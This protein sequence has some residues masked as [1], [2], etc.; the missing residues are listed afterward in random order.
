MTNR[1][2]T[3]SRKMMQDALLNLLKEKPYQKISIT[4][5]NQRADLS[6][7][8]FYEHFESKDDLLISLVD[9]ILEPIFVEMT[10]A[11]AAS[12]HGT[13]SETAF[14]M[15]FEQWQ[16]NEEVLELIR[17]TKSD[18]LILERLHTWFQSA[19]DEALYP[20]IKNYNQLM[21]DYTISLIAGAFYMALIRWA[22][23]GMRHPPELMGRYLFAVLGPPG[24]LETRLE[25]TE[26]F[27]QYSA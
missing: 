15:L 17:Q 13:R 9:D 27:D 11:I 19:R 21:A 3:R 23:E 2:A 7:R 8:T 10:E 24:L 20:Q 14:I 1:Q 5:V 16:A 12:V 22:Q 26:M 6:R 4:E 18:L 25:F